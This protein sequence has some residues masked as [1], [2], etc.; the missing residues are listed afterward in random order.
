MIIQCQAC[1]QEGTLSGVSGN[2]I[3]WRCPKCNARHVFS[4]SFNLLS[5]LRL[6]D[7]YTLPPNLKC[8]PSVLRD[9]R[10]AVQ[11]FN[12]NA[13]R[14]AA[15][16]VRLALE[17]TCIELGAAG[18]TLHAKIEDLAARGIFDKLLV[19]GAMAM[20]LYGNAG[21]HA[22]DDLLDENGEHVEYSLKMAVDLLAKVK[23]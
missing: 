10:E 7:R 12:A 21:A 19:Q 5:A 13:P 18:N 15:V 11:C 9:L 20:R 6:V 4:G 14:A 17:R 16:M 3:P 2:E 23:L 1:L 8:S 22:K